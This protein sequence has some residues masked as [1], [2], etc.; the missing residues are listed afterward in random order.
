MAVVPHLT[1]PRHDAHSSHP[2][3]GSQWALSMLI[4]LLE[5]PSA[6]RPRPRLGPE[7]SLCSEQKHP[8]VLCDPTALGVS[9]LA[10]ATLAGVAAANCVLCCLPLDCELLAGR[11]HMVTLY[12]L[13][14]KSV[15]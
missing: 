7:W 5:C 6:L 15:V 12:L 14:R 1:V 8:V 4:S 10:L 3:L 2:D 9:L 13:D 11:D